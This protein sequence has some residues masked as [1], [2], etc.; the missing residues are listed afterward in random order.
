MITMLKVVSRKRDAIVNEEENRAH[1][2]L[3]PY[4]CSRDSVEYLFQYDAHGSIVCNYTTRRNVCAH[5]RNMAPLINGQKK[6][7]LIS[8][9]ETL[10]WEEEGISKGMSCF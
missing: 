9:I 8:N 10:G 4:A 3:L 1:P 6:G 7:K 2:L 5:R